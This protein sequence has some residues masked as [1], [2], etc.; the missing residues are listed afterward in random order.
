MLTFSFGSLLTPYAIF[1]TPA[2]GQENLRT[3]GDATSKT[4]T[5]CEG[6]KKYTESQ[7]ISK[8]E[9]DSN[10]EAVDTR[11]DELLSDIIRNPWSEA[12]Q[13]KIDEKECLSEIRL[14]EMKTE[15]TFSGTA[16]T[17]FGTENSTEIIRYL[18]FTNQEYGISFEY[19]SYWNVN[20]KISRFSTGPDVE[21]SDGLNA[22]K[23]VKD[24][25]SLGDSEFFDLKFMANNFQK[26]AL[27]DPEKRLIEKVD[28]DTYQINGKD[29]ASFLF[30]GK[31]SFD[32]NSLIKTDYA[33]QVFVIEN[34]DN[35]DI[36]MYQ[37][38]IIRFDTPESQGI[39]NHILDSFKFIDSESSDPSDNDDDDDNASRS[40]S[41]NNDNDDE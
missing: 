36:L 30:T 32:E 4:Y 12:Q 23:F 41:N 25:T 17:S 7:D 38:T 31:Y 27:E 26:V 24:K 9:A 14:A 15:G 20:E 3:N 33:T 2:I 1:E 6:Y 19:P 21:V 28:L 37:D 22:F 29:T 40:S 5:D 35:F 11:I 8:E 13:V 34:R 16:N 10:I 39:M 18:P